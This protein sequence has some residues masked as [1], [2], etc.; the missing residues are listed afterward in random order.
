MPLF[1]NPKKKIMEQ[2]FEAIENED[3]ATLSQLISSGQ[4]DI[5]AKTLESRGGSFLIYSVSKEKKSA[6]NFLI[7]NKAEIDIRLPKS[8]EAPIHFA[9]NLQDSFFLKSLVA[10]KAN[11]NIKDDHYD[12]PLQYAIWAHRLEN[13]KILVDAGANVDTADCIGST[14]IDDALKF[15][16][17]GM[18]KYLLDKGARFPAPVGKFNTRFAWAYELR[19]QRCR[20]K[21]TIV[22]VVGCFRR[23][24]GMG[25][26]MARLMGHI[27]W[28]ERD[29]EEWE[30][31]SKTEIK[32]GR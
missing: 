13:V 23:R 6:F 25:R 31:Q 14:P 5:N 18:F 4:V 26:D 21:R 15:N 1:S 12:T 19:S 28:G 30:N 11:V 7:A 9:A 17:K 29:H 24:L 8:M 32:K 3:I 22:V 27:L 10:L 20:V 16:G 2:G